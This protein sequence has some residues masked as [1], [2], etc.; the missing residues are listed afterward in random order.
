MLVLSRKT[1][2]TIKIGDNVYITIVDIDNTKV[3]I[4]IEA[5]KAITVHRLEI[6]Q[7]IEKNQQVKEGSN[8]EAC[9]RLSAR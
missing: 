3:R 5:P 2:E 6:A 4:G 1:G 9:D 7:A 8:P